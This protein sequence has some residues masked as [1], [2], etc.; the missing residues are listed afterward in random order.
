MKVAS[1]KTLSS[2]GRLGQTS[3]PDLASCAA[4]CAESF[5]DS[6]ANRCGV[7]VANAADPMKA[8]GLRLSDSDKE[9]IEQK[10]ELAVYE[11]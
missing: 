7:R 5:A 2:R 4:S 1:R 3:S 10:G 11:V 9:Q 8:R 6:C